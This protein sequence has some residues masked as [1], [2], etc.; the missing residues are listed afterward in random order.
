MKKSST[1]PV[2]VSLPLAFQDGRDKYDGILRF[3]TTSGEAWDIRLVRERMTLPLLSQAVHDGARGTIMDGFNANEIFSALAA[4]E[5]PVIALDPMRPELL[6]GRKR[7]IAFIDIDSVDI[8]QRAADYLTGQGDYN[9]YGFIGY[10]E[11]C[12]W[13]DLREQTFAAALS[14]RGLACDSFKVPRWH[15]QTDET[16]QN[17]RA[18]LAAMPKPAAV[19]AAHDELARTALNLCVRESLRVPE[20]IAVL[21]VD[22]ELIVCTHTQP[23]LSSIRPDFE[24][25]G[26]EAARLLSAFLSGKTHKRIS[27]VTPILGIIGRESTAPSSPA[28]KMVQRASEYIRAN[29]TRDIRVTSVAKALSVSRRLL[30]LRFRQIT[31]RTILDA[32]Q[33]VRLEQVKTLLR[34]TAMPIQ[35]I[36]ETCSF[37]SEN[38]LKRMFKKWTGLTMRDFR[39][40]SGR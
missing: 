25:S 30:D 37:R 10:G 1:V 40:K 29:A 12:K 38:H 26:Y 13:S 33:D 19:L 21:G 8:G 5:I 20:E 36:G 24:Q 14:R 2:L 17:L 28:G 23:T 9:A 32:I 18:W 4:M 16:N 6:E 39:R 7:D 34:T 35:E 11:G 15:A 22:N 3:L 27:V 31:G